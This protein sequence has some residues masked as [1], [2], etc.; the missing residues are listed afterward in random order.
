M[1]INEFTA[2]EEEISPGPRFITIAELM[3]RTSLSRPTIY[4]HIK[5]G[6]IPGFH[7]GRCVIVDAEFLQELKAR[8]RSTI[9]GKEDGK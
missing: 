1:D 4:R 3:K 6:V 9:S 8:G 2:L 5:A 7:V